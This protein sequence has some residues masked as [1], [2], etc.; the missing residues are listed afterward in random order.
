MLG[1]VNRLENFALHRFIRYI[2]DYIQEICCVKL[3][4]MDQ[5]NG[6][7]IA[8]YWL[9]NYTSQWYG[10]RGVSKILSL[11]IIDRIAICLSSS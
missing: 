2:T 7:F 4:K 10:N 8:T 1:L 3:D 11:W 5:L 6:N 9:W